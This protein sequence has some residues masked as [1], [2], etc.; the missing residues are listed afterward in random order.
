MTQRN[1]LMGNGTIPTGAVDWIAAVLNTCGGAHS[2]SHS[3][4]SADPSLA[5][6]LTFWAPPNCA[7]AKDLS[8]VTISASAGTV[9]M[10]YSQAFYLYTPCW[11]LQQNPL[12]HLRKEGLNSPHSAPRLMAQLSTGIA[13]CTGAA[14]SSVSGHTEIP[15][16]RAPVPTA[17]IHF[18]ECIQSI[19]K[20]QISS[21][22]HLCRWLTG[23]FLDHLGNPRTWLNLSY[24]SSC[25]NFNEP[26]TVL[27]SLVFLF[28]YNFH[29]HGLSVSPPR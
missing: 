13:L 11:V 23:E 16:W 15:T 27:W 22:P 28:K 5:K 14:W 19:T 20:F 1:A 17:E 4:T 12:R 25:G 2:P 21:L 10:E 3:D 24:F 26:Y 6:I 8:Y 29:I 7:F 18:W 9:C